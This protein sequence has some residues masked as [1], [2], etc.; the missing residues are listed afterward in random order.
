MN[1]NADLFK[2]NHRRVKP[3]RGRKLIAEPLL[4]GSIF[5]RSV[6]LLVEYSSPGSVG[7]VLNKPLGFNL[8][9]VVP[10]V[11]GV[12]APIPMFS[13]GP[14]GSDRLFYVHRLG[15]LIPNA[16]ELSE[17]LYI[18]GDFDSV[19]SYVKSGNRVDGNICFFLGYSGWD[20]GQLDAEIDDETWVV[21][22]YGGVDLNACITGESYWVDAVRE[23][24]PDYK[25]W[26]SYP[27]TPWL[28]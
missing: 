16:I 18:D 9:Q 19:I 17:G 4:S 22:P 11:S 25:V 2:I 15:H 26:L 14:V 24:G 23:M 13:G 10:V 3:K 1:V 7:L 8:Q 28:N 21:S 27:K 6:V 12:E 5:Q 20:E